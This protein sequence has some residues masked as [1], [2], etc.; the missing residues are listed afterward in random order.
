MNIDRIISMVI[1]RITFRATDAGISKGIELLS[2]R[3][4]READMTPEERQQ[5]A[6]TSQDARQ[7]AKNTRKAMRVTRRMR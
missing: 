1:R 2:R 6:K 3:G 7:M 4:K 5:A